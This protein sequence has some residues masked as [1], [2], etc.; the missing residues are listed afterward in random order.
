MD[1]N[2]IPIMGFFYLL[3]KKLH[4]CTALVSM[5][6]AMVMAIHANIHDLDF[7]IGFAAENY[8]EILLSLAIGFLFMSLWVETRCKEVYLV[9]RNR[10]RLGN[11]RIV[12][13]LM[14]FKN[15]VSQVA[16]ETRDEKEFKRFLQLF[17]EIDNE[18]III[19]HK[20][21]SLPDWDPEKERLMV[22]KR[23]NEA[24]ANKVRYAFRWIFPPEMWKN[25][26]R[27]RDDEAPE[28]V[29]LDGRRGSD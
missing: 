29:V 26:P 6:A 25:V 9:Y 3:S 2:E 23:Y 22:Q 12:R 19:N 5:L 21:N 11:R 15:S 7:G 27:I 4:L 8:V 17:Y 18:R 10:L 14:V 1:E 24:A 20:I 16:E 28:F 13:S